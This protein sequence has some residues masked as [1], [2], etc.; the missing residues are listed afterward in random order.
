MT[1]N[2]K[3]FPVGSSL[4]LAGA[5]VGAGIFS[6]PRIFAGAL[7]QAS[8]LLVLAV[9]AVASVHLLFLRA[10]ESRPAGNHHHL[11]GLLFERYGQFAKFIGSLLVIGGLFLA[12]CAQ[13]LL[14]SNIISGL[15]L[16]KFEWALLLVSILFFI[17]LV[18]SHKLFFGLE[19]YAAVAL[20]VMLTVLAIG[21]P[22]SQFITGSHLSWIEILG[23]ILFACSSWT[24][25]PAL[26]HVAK[27]RLERTYAVILAGIY[28]ALLYFFFGFFLSHTAAGYTNDFFKAAALWPP[29]L[30]RL[31]GA[32]AF[33]AVFLSFGHLSR[34]LR[35]T[36]LRDFHSN[37]IVTSAGII[38]LPFVV[39]ISG[40]RGFISLAAFAGGVFIAGEYLAILAVSLPASAPRGLKIA[41]ALSG[42]LFL[43]A[44]GAQLGYVF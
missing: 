20:V 28:V 39:I 40:V 27:D 10:L 31:A 21:V 32:I 34:E 33:S 37:Q 35:S 7:W 13:I 18:L 30:A 2:R 22:R 36:L 1:F 8:I 42:I 6:L 4:F 17:P 44:I 11:P 41:A 29:V 24:A 3:F 5:A 25:V 14:S 43:V 19:R 16:L 9:A 23:A 15:F 26:L 38:I 12:A